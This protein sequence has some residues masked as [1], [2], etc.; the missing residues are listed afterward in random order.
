MTWKKLAVIVVPAVAL[1]LG[2]SG[3]AEAANLV[4]NGGFESFTGSTFDT[5]GTNNKQYFPTAAPTGWSGGSGL[6]FLDAP[7]TADNSADYLAVYGPFPSTSP[8]GGNFVEADGDPAYS[9]TAVSQTINGLTAGQSYTVTFYTAAGQQLDFTGPTTEWWT[10]GFG[11][12]ATQ[13][14]SVFTLAQGGVGPWQLQTMTFVADG[15]SDVLSFLSQGTPSVQPP[16]DFLD[17][18]SVVPTTSVPLPGP[19]SLAAFGLLGLGAVG[20]LYR[21]GKSAAV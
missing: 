4:T 1:A 15:T 12:D 3:G 14:S 13:N 20:L 10:V 2:A 9:H 7:G 11:G 5:G 17:G 18:V 16:I 8:N 6:T 21:R 19:L